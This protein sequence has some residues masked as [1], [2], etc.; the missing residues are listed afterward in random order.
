MWIASV[1]F[2]HGYKLFSKDKHFNFVL[3]MAQLGVQANI[4][5]KLHINE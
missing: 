1:V 4:V 3:G 5:P 2:Q